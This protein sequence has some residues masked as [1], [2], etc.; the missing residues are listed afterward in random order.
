MG[1]LMSRHGYPW[2]QPHA[3]MAQLS[4]GTWDGLH[5]R[6][7]VLPLWVRNREAVVATGRWTDAHERTHMQPEEWEVFLRIKLLLR[8]VL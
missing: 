3:W 6:G 2:D 7:L 5:V 4:I 8:C 1:L